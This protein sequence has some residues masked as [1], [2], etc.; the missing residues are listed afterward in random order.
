MEASEAHLE[1]SFTKAL[2]RAVRQRDAE[3]AAELLASETISNQPDTVVEWIEAQARA[4]EPEEAQCWYRIMQH[5][6]DGAL[7]NMDYYG[8]G[9]LHRAYTRASEGILK[10]R[11][12]ARAGG[13]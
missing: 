4:A 7:E 1:A 12:R 13:K 2:G 3:F 11:N 5:Y 6:I 10:H 8:T 9:P